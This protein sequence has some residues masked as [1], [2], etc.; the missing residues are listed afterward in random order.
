MDRARL[1]AIGWLFDAQRGASN[2]VI[3]RWLFLR[4]LGGIYFSAFFP[5]VFQI[6][7]L[8][9]PAG[10]LPAGNYLQ[11]VAQALGHGQRYWYAPTLLWWSS[12]TMMLSALCWVGMLV[13]LLLLLNL[14]TKR[15]EFGGLS[16]VCRR[17]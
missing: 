15:F 9:G 2:R 5:L 10:I 14:S 12:G 8:I 13:S 11:A 4:A 6:R 16:G 7:V 17:R 3:P 1:S